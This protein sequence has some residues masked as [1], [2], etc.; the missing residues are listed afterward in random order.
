MFR[1][2][3]DVDRHV[4]DVFR[5]LKDESERNLRCYNI[6]KL[7]FQVGDYESAK[8][9]VSNYL[10]IRTE[11][12]GAHKLLGQILEALGHKEDAL[13]QYKISL[14]LES[15]QDDLVLKV[16]ELL[17]DMDV[18]VDVNRARYWVERAD[19]QFP[20]HP[21][22][23]QLKE[24]LLTLDKP[25][26]DGE[27]LKALISSELSVRPKDVQLRVKL[28]KHY[29]EKDKLDEAYK[30]AFEV[31][32]TQVH[33]DDVS[34]YQVLCDLLTKC[35]GL[36]KHDWSF[37]VF[38]ISAL[39]RFVALTLKEQGSILKK[40]IS[41]A[42]QALFNFDQ[43]LYEAK[44]QNFSTNP[45]FME[46]MFT[47]MWGQLHFHV[48]CLILRKTKREQG[49]WSE[50]GRLC[51]PLFLTAL[52]VTPVDPTSPWAV[53]LKN[54]SKNQV[55]LWYK[56]GS[57]RCS[58]ACHVLQDYARD[59]PNR[60][61]E[62]IDKFCTG[63]WRDR[64]FQRIFISRLYSE[65]KTSYFATHK[66]SNSPL[67]LC[68]QNELKKYDEISEEVWP[69]SL[70][71]Q[72]WLGITNR[73]RNSAKKHNLYPHQ[74]CHLFPE[75]QF[76][77][78]NI[79][80]SAPDSLSRLD[81]DAFLNA[82][83]LCSYVTIE[84][85][86][87][88]S[89]LNPERLPTL[90]ADLTN[91][92]CSSVQEKW[93]FNA[94]KMYR[95]Q[96]V[97]M[98]DMGEI[99]QEIQR[100]L[101][102]VRCIGNHGL[103]PNI[104]VHLARIFHFRI[105]EL[106]EKNPEHSDIPALEARCELYW[107][108]AI[109]LLERL[110]NNQ[111]IRTSN[112]KIFDYQGKDMSRSELTK[113]MEEGRLLLVQKHV[114]NKE[115]ERAIDALQAL[116]CPEA[117]FEQGKIYKAL[118]D[119]L[120]K[121]LPRESLTS[122]SRSQNGILL[123]KA[124]S[125]FYL[126]LDRLR[127]PEADTKH[128]LNSE[129]VTH[130]A[131]IE[132]ELKRIE[133]DLSRNGISRNDCD[134]LSEDS[135]SSAH[136]NEE[137]PI[138]NSSINL[139]STVHFLQTPQ[140][141]SHRTPKQSSTP[142]RIPH[143]DVLELS[144]NRIEARPSPERL[145]AQIRQ[146]LHSKDNIVQTLMDQNKALMESHQIMMEKLE[147]VRKEV[148]E[149]RLENKKQ[150]PTPTNQNLEEDLYFLNDEDYGEYNYQNTTPQQPQ[151]APLAG[152]LFAQSPR[153]P[154]PNIVYPSAT[155][156]GQAI[157]YYQGA[158]PFNDP[159]HHLHSSLYAANVYPVPPVAQMYP[160]L[161]VDPQL[162]QI[163]KIT[164]SILQQALFNQVPPAIS[165][166]PPSMIQQQK[167]EKTD[168]PKESVIKNIPLNK[169][170]PVN[171][172]ITSSDTLPTTAPS[173]QPIMSVTIPPQ[174]RLG[175]TAVPHSYQ[176]SMPSQ[177]TIPT[178]VNLPPLAATLTVSSPM[179]KSI[180]QSINRANTS[181]T[182]HNNS[183]ELCPE[184]EHDP[185]PDFVPIIPLPEE[186]IVTTGEENETTLFS[187]RA[188]L[189]RFADKEWKER[190]IGKVKLLKNEEGKIRLLMRREQVHKIC[191]NHMLTRDIELTQMPSNNKAW[192]WVA[193]DF[194][195]EEVRLEK[196]CIRFKLEEEAQLFKEAVDGAIRSLPESPEKS[197]KSEKKV[198]EKKVETKMDLKTDSSVIKLGGLSFSSE[199]VVQKTVVVEEKKVQK[200]EPPKVNPFAQFSFGKS[201]LSSGTTATAS[202]PLG[203][204]SFVKSADSESPQTGSIFGG[205]KTSRF[206]TCSSNTAANKSA[207]EGTK[208]N[209]EAEIADGEM[210]IFEH[211][212]NLMHL[213]STTK[214]WE[215]KGSGQINV[216][217]NVKT[218]KMRFLMLNTSN[219]QIICNQQISWDM[220]FF[221]R[222]TSDTVITW[223]IPNEKTKK[224]D[225]FAV[226]FKNQ[227]SAKEFLESVQ[228]YQQ[229]L[230][231]TSTATSE[232]K[233][234]EKSKEPLSTLFKPTAGSWE[235]K[236]CYIRNNANQTIC[237]ACNTPAVE[238]KI[239]TKATTTPAA[240]TQKPLSELFK[241]SAGS[242][243]CQGCYMVNKGT[244]QQCPACDTPKEPSKAKTTNAAPTSTTTTGQK[245]LS[246]LFKPAAGSW[247][248]QGCYMVNKGADQYCPACDTPK[249]PSMPPKPKTNS[250]A[251]KADSTSSSTFTFGFPQTNKE[252]TLSSPATSAF[253]FAALSNTKPKADAVN[254]TI[255]TIFGGSKKT[256][257][258]STNFTFGTP[259]RPTTPPNTTKPYVFGSPGKSFDFQFSAKPS[260]K[261]PGGG[262]SGNN[263]GETSEDEVVESDDIYF[264]PVIPLPDKV[265]VKTGEEDEEI[266]YSH[267][268]KL[269]RFDSNT[270]E[271]K[272]RGL[273]DIKLLRHNKTKKLR[274]I[275]RRDQ[276][277]KLCLNHALTP[278]IEVSVRDDKTWTWS[279]ADYSEGE[280]EYSQ[281]ACRFKTPEIAQ[282]FKT[283]IDN[284]LAGKV[285]EPKAKSS[286]DIEIIYEKR[287]TAQEKEEA[288]KLKLPENFYSYKYNED[289]PGCIGCR[290]P[291]VP[292]FDTRSTTGS[293]IKALD[294]SK[295]ESKVE[296]SPEIVDLSKMT[297][298]PVFS[299]SGSMNK[300]SG[301]FFG[302]LT[303]TPTSGKVETP[304]IEKSTSL[305]FGSTLTTQSPSDKM[306]ENLA[307]QK[308]KS[309]DTVSTTTTSLPTELPTSTAAATFSFAD[310]SKTNATPIFGSKPFSSSIFGGST[311]NSLQ[312]STSP[313]KLEG[314]PAEESKVSTLFS[315]FS[316]TTTTATVAA[317]TPT[318]FGNTTTTTTTPTIFGNTATTTPTIFGNTTT[319][320][321]TIFGN[322]TAATTTTPSI[323]GGTTTTTTSTLFGN[324]TAVATPTLFGNTGAAATTT[325]VF[326]SGNSEPVFGSS[327][328]SALSFSGLKNS[329]TTGAT[330]TLGFGNKP[331]FGGFGTG[332]NTNS[333]FNKSA[334][335]TFGAKKTEAV[336]E[337]INFLPTENAVSFSTLAAKNDQNAFK[338]DPNFSFEGAGSSVFGSKFLN[339]NNSNLNTSK[340][341]TSVTEQ[342]EN[343]NK[344]ED[345][346]TEQ[347]HDPHFEPIIPLPDAIE[348]RTGE[349]DEEK[350]FCQRAK[351]YRF[352]SNTKEWKERGVGEMKLL[353]HI[354][355]GTYRLILRR[356]QVHKIVCNMLLN[357]DLD[358]EPLQT[359]DRAWIWAGMNYYDGE[360]NLEKL[361]IRFKSPELASQFKEAI[362]KAQQALREKPSTKQVK[363]N[364]SDSTD[365]EKYD[366]DEEDDD[367][368]V[369]EG[370]EEDFDG[371]EVEEEEEISY[372]F[373][374]R[375]TL[376]AQNDDQTWTN[377]GMG[378]LKI[379]Y[380]SEIFGARIIME[381]DST[382]EIV[383]NTIIS[384]DTSMQVVGKECLWKAYD[385]ILNPPKRRLLKATF[386][387][388]Q[389]A[390]E[391]YVNF[392][393]GQ[394]YA[395]GAEIRDQPEIYIPD[396]E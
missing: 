252:T 165:N 157:G 158:L 5:K 20:H 124:R 104:L 162:N 22:V 337:K 192:I 382:G 225:S 170:P 379:F 149:L 27:D 237:V 341:N 2:K 103:H 377:L 84:E 101:E 36:R 32:T 42:T 361:A 329:P 145:D 143:Q 223:V 391:M 254:T 343:E 171:V 222:A 108:T 111:V 166:I 330:S 114:R 241:P 69:A 299:F 267:R 364:V 188:K 230:G 334:D 319:A 387:S 347:E 215:D 204:I 77:T 54:E 167:M 152:N 242:W 205:S 160:R 263:G 311:F 278:D 37:W 10:E 85:Q 119:D 121:S 184:Q 196:F 289:C 12:E 344:E 290:E 148:A 48:A 208:G 63:S 323:F 67:R 353:H 260:A 297:T 243:T 131:D 265:D 40:S 314:K 123:T 292:L 214:T 275:M 66:A 338:K 175:T 19:K 320:T 220:K 60:L 378:Y 147:E 256:E 369:E 359:S 281:F 251:L 52:H 356:E 355:G 284:A 198:V 303:A 199:P 211:K 96:D 385:Y 392:E 130:I 396:E 393:D 316:G 280:I 91:T 257:P 41:E 30:H 312:K 75:L 142:C 25:N 183:L 72:T 21:V 117:S 195:D 182:S 202:Q 300:P 177:A 15:R 150:K 154:Y 133:P 99:R 49:S 31:E 51:A 181:S 218:I 246:E 282:E 97:T 370:D 261:S 113:A 342:D 201:G 293:V 360:A 325:P 238:K 270:K 8:R 109:P 217:F 273:G 58:Q 250:F 302:N 310:T 368:Y 287:V 266:V 71:H 232:R 53:H 178:T 234:A 28:L 78:Y 339:A 141:N 191:A 1:T 16:C 44:S 83:I 362:D 125:C 390:E 372:M 88:S 61:L 118:A 229:T 65:N 194:A 7:Y 159:N 380:D 239:E 374:K 248:C 301:G 180:E 272:E 206:P 219:S 92:L 326:G 139:E 333:I 269:F 43:S 161:P 155:L 331:V 367:D 271:W 47:H 249:D 45:I 224:S 335:N 146:L 64:I 100:G 386:S 82:A 59:E 173:V 309:T 376:F 70:H 327:A 247:T 79:N 110:Q 213:N 80:Q 38:Y 164:D 221:F 89:F 317:T 81:I 286:D 13:S 375:A 186:V 357:A 4:Q 366:Q 216:L 288:K 298:P 345:E 244:D 294:F 35:K 87:R 126:T 56:D 315:G 210:S 228:N 98:N 207:I 277:L 134:A 107:S 94:Y 115:Y 50:A 365:Q 76:S 226:N 112:N 264:A 187:A 394:D 348:V 74:A 136:S 255:S 172:V 285:T 324:T 321:P 102:V 3:L 17:A 105:K 274:L 197:K 120:V 189:Y 116:K 291:E 93:W 23:F 156:Q 351:L 350:V 349:E 153:H 373:E 137:I 55:N 151:P 190:G 135:Y 132:N 128:P 176:I 185:I 227:K 106:Q 384:I 358:F 268:A 262:A 328:T 304:T 209:K 46:N 179:N 322:T 90:P 336:P 389:G 259:T 231:K 11:S 371:E 34:W 33:R 203:G 68:S 307:L 6:A 29:M 138:T 388:V 24:K 95:R 235:C 363:E 240:Q 296:K 283:S 233:P 395:K 62:K 313:T 340:N 129:L 14:E 212:A 144:R 236:A 381:V 193:N 346:E 308:A 163:P 253:S 245:S 306:N 26:N 39:E 276:I 200:E 383:S 305:V 86:Q 295:S 318:I 122:E 354:E 9:Y 174:H 18:G 127:S 332:T 57:Y 73:P 279:A 169:Q 352:D 140:R 258:I 168:S